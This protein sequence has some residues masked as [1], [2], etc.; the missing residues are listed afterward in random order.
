MLNSVIR[1][2]AY[3]TVVIKYLG[4]YGTVILPEVMVDGT[5]RY[6]VR[7]TNEEGK[8]VQKY[9]YENEL[10]I[11]EDNEIQIQSAR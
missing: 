4:V 11:K 1:L 6:L 8:M 5:F 3:D 9:F 7:Y 2:F 10:G